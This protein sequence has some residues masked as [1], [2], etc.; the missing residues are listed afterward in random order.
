MRLISPL[1]GRKLS[2]AAPEL[3][4]LPPYRIGMALSAFTP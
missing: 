1:T 2:A 3:A 4:L